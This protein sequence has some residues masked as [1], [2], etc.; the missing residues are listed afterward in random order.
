MPK[1]RPRPAPLRP[2]LPPSLSP[3]P[4]LRQILLLQLTFYAT[5]TLLTFFTT[6]IAGY[7][8]SAS[9]ILGAPAWVRGD[10][11][12]G[13]MFGGVW[14][15]VAGVCVL[16]QILI[17]AR[18]KLVLDFTL[19]QYFL[20]FVCTWIYMGGYPW[21]WTGGRW[22]WWGVQ[23]VCCVGTVVGGRWGCG[24]REMRPMA[25]GGGAGEGGG[26]GGGGE[27]G[28]GVEMVPLVRGEV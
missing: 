4:L 27:V 23:V 1:P 28:E 11:V 26:G 16:A 3:L 25:F 13:W 2:L 10:T 5:A 22:E 19:T 6:S 18:S 12:Q 20:H 24:W 7:P 15:L 14:V 8:F 17:L 9:L 21:E